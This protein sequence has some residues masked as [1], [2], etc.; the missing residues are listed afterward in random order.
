MAKSTRKNWAIL[1]FSLP[2]AGI[3]IGFLVLSIIPTLY[4]WRQMSSWP[5]TQATVIS[6]EL[7]SHQGDDSTTYEATGNYQY[8]IGGNSYTAV[9]LGISGGAD[10]VG[11]W[12]QQ[13]DEKLRYSLHNNSPISIYYSPDNPAEAIVDRQPR[14]GLLGFKM[15][16]V[17]AFGGVGIGLLWWS[18][19]NRNK[20]IDIPEAGDKP[21]LGHKDWASA[22]I[23]SDAKAKHYLL[24]GVTLIWNLISS[25]LLFA[26]PK[27][28]EKGN[29]A[30]F[31]AAVFP[32]IGVALFIW[33]VKTTRRWLGIGATPLTLD[34]YPGSIGGQV[35]GSIETNIHYSAAHEFPITLSCLYS[36]VSGSG[37]NR[38]RKESVK[39]QTQG[40]AQAEPA[41][42]GSR[43]KFSFDLPAGL[44]ESESKD[45]RYHF[46]RLSL[47]SQGLAVDMD[48]NFELP[49]FNTATS[50]RDIRVNSITHPLAQEKRDEQ[51]ESVMEM[52][53]VS[54]GLELYFPRGRNAGVKLGV[55]VFGLVFLGSGIG[56]GAMGAP[57]IFPITFGLIGGGVVLGG[58]YGLLNSLAVHI[59]HDGIHSQRKLLGLSI[60]RHAARAAEVRELRIHKGGSMTSGTE[61]KI[62]YS[63]KAHLIDGG[64]ITVAESLIGQQAAQQAAEAIAIYSGFDCDTKIV[65]QGQEFADRKRAY[66]ARKKQ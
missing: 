53:Q 64:K 1:L 21:W 66:L 40:F 3:G 37:K 49:V 42:R 31:I 38:S 5:E 8:Q 48:R 44:P 10:N 61:H 56:A 34:P 50:S 39:W 16:F 57:I 19:K 23:L 26:I 63:I 24:W 46:W 13:M 12:H 43:L 25:P 28:L 47:K 65:D 18:I 7:Q 30:I 41:G 6:A 22:T 20:V 14:W 35:G 58:L 27:E 2:F 62:F 36:Y 29:N 54:G 59:G 60:G 32:L 11:D 52:R 17:L 9:R 55:I 15:I 45:E 4:E 51:I 33:A